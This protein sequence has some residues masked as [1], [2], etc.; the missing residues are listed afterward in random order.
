ML[1]IKIGRPMTE[2]QARET[3]CPVLLQ[4]QPIWN[5]CYGEG[6]MWWMWVDEIPS[7]PV[8]ADDIVELLERNDEAKERLGFC[9]K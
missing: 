4:S 6:C 2:K 1:A 3:L 9:C 7:G 8:P 5:K